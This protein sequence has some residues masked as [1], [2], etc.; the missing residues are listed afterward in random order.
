MQLRF[1]I[2]PHVVGRKPNTY[3]KSVRTGLLVLAIWKIGSEGCSEDSN[4]SNFFQLESIVPESAVKEKQVECGYARVK[5]EIINTD[6]GW[7]E[8]NVSEIIC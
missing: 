6:R 3:T 8:R 7:P 4:M 5:G 1:G 2:S